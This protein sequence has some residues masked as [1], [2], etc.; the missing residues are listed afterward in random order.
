MD[1]DLSMIM[2]F[3]RSQEN[4]P[5]K[6]AGQDEISP[7]TKSISSVASMAMIII[8]MLGAISTLIAPNPFWFGVALW[9]IVI[10]FLPILEHRE[11]RLLP[12]WL[13]LPVVL[14]FIAC[15]I[16]IV[17]GFRPL[18]MAAPLSWLISAIGLFF[19]CLITTIFI[20][21]KG[22]MQM[23]RPFFVGATFFFL[24][25]V[26]VIQGWVGWYS[27]LLQ[28]TN[29][30]P[31]STVYMVYNILVTSTCLVL[32]LSV[33]F[34]FRKRPYQEFKARVVAP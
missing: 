17:G 18:D 3:N 10:S 23:N 29:L 6:D 4:D 20:D 33:Y 28:G 2:I 7:M 27:D 30:V 22:D 1:A 8:L 34:H 15:S 13:L 11:I 24:E 9:A 32:A 16:G 19:L 31:S 21:L 12:W 5:E 26:V 14:P 25:S